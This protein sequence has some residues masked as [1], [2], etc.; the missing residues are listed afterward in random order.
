M[1]SGVK[2]LARFCKLD[3]PFLSVNE[4]ALVSKFKLGELL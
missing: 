3:G 2:Q 4:L 1:G